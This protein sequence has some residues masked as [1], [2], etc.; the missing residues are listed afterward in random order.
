MKLKLLLASAAVLV[1]LSA[2]QPT[3]R[4]C[5]STYIQKSEIDAYAAR[6]KAENIVDQQIR[7][8]DLGKSNV[9]AGVVYRGKLTAPGLWPSMIW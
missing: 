5:S 9:A 2:Q 8:V 3:C 7:A 1:V 6:G 4:N